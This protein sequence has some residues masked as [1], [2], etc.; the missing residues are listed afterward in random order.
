MKFIILC[1]S[2]FIYCIRYVNF[3][4]F[5]LQGIGKEHAKFSPVTAISF[6][7]EPSI[8]INDEEFKNLKQEEKEELRTICPTKVFS[9]DEQNDQLLNFAPRNCTYCNECIK[10]TR[11]KF[12]RPNLI[13]IKPKKGKYIF[14]VE[15][16]FAHLSEYVFII[17]D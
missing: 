8:L 10:L 14:N 2:R 12:E 1:L 11:D 9:Y 4:F 6:Q 3:L 13:K 17:F 5:W 16:C 7:H 15:V